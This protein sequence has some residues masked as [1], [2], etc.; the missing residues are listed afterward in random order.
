MNVIVC[1]GDGLR[2]MLFIDVKYILDLRIKM[3]ISTFFNTKVMV[4]LN[5]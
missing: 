2:C 5:V 1:D 4:F 3:V